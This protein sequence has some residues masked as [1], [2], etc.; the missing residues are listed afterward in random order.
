VQG[1]VQGGYNVL[2]E[3]LNEIERA[4]KDNADA[5]KARSLRKIGAPLLSYSLTSIAVS[6]SAAD[7]VV[8]YFTGNVPKPLNGIDFHLVT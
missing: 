3:T 8:L 2:P 4:V 7:R 1:F 6:P 5:L